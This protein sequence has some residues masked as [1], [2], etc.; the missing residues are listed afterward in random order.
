M[1]IEVSIFQMSFFILYYLLGIRIWIIV[2]L[3]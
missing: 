1:M 3:S 2:W